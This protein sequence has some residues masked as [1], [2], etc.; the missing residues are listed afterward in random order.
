MVFLTS[1]IF[2]VRHKYIFFDTG[3]IHIRLLALPYFAALC[4]YMSQETSLPNTLVLFPF[5]RGWLKNLVWSRS[6]LG[7]II[8]IIYTINFHLDFGKN[9]HTSPR[10][11]YNISIHIWKTTPGGRLGSNPRRL[12]GSMA[13]VLCEA[14]FL[15]FP[16]LI[17]WDWI[18]PGGSRNIS[19]LDIVFFVLN[20]E[21]LLCCCFWCWHKNF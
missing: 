15:G 7:S 18:R 11:L 16:G 12:Q 1:M 9:K 17:S 10:E 19:E 21:I 20:I 8:Y 6:L 4:V 14:K 5:G 2:Y 3:S 13:L